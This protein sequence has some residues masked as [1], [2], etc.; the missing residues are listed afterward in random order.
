MANE[1][2]GI[3]GDS[4]YLCPC[5]WGLAI[6]ILEMPLRWE[7]LPSG[8]MLRQEMNE[9]LP[10]EIKTSLCTTWWGHSHASTNQHS[11][12]LAF[13]FCSP[14]SAHFYHEQ[15]IFFLF[16]DL[17]KVRCTNVARLMSHIN[18]KRRMLKSWINKKVWDRM[19]TKLQLLFYQYGEA[20]HCT[21][22]NRSLTCFCKLGA[23][24][25]WVDLQSWSFF[26]WNIFSARCISGKE[27]G[28]STYVRV[29][30]CASKFG[31]RPSTTSVLR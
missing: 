25:L 1:W 26:S 5:K 22:P 15:V 30:L 29:A 20:M 7:T 4:W 8:K 19:G 14:V 11:M 6:A 23:E 24:K 28:G 27:R 13:V 18:L 21:C 12:C 2:H 31:T 17:G 16:T 9:H 10:I 3:T